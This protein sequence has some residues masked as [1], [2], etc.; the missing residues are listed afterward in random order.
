MND[1]TWVF[2]FMVLVANPE[3]AF[4]SDGTM[5]FWF[6]GDAGAA[7]AGGFEGVIKLAPVPEPV[8]MISGFLAVCGLGA[9]IRRHMRAPAAA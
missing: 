2:S 1:P 3:S 7:D 5:K 9:F 8:T 4:E 6:G